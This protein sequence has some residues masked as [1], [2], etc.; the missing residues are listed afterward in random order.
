MRLGSGLESDVLRVRIGLDEHFLPSGWH[1][2]RLWRG[3]ESEISWGRKV[4]RT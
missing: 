3:R 1:E 4:L 2:M